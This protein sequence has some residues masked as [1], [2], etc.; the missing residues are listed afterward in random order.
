[1]VLKLRCKNRSILADIQHGFLESSI[2]CISDAINI[3]KTI[4]NPAAKNNCVRVNKV[5]DIGDSNSEVVSNL[6]NQ[7]KTKIITL[8]RLNYANNVFWNYFLGVKCAERVVNISIL[9]MKDQISRETLYRSCGSIFFKTTFA[10]AGAKSCAFAYVNFHVTNLTTGK[11]TSAIYLSVN[12]DSRTDA[13][14]NKYTNKMLVLLA[15]SE[16]HFRQSRTSYII[17]YKYIFEVD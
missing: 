16:M 9:Y 17:V 2:K 12:D 4:Y 5:S 1:V 14:T 8:I 13:T 15:A 6:P 7:I 11:C 10:A 3:I